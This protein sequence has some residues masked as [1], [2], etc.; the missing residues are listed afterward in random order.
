MYEIVVGR[1]DSDRKALGIQGSVFLGKHY[2]RMG[3]TTSLSNKIY[4]DVAKTHVVL[5]SGKRGCLTEESMIFT[6]KGYKKINEFDIIKDKIY[7]FNKEK[8]NFILEKAKLLKYK[9]N[10]ELYNIKLDD[11]QEIVATAEHPFLVKANKKYS[12]KIASELNTE[13]KIVSLLKLPNKK[14]NERISESLARL[15]GFTL[16]DGTLFVRKGRFKDGRGYWYNG[17]IKRLRIF[18]AENEVLESAK[19]DIEKEFGVTARRYKRKDCNCEVIEARH[20]KIINKLIELGVPTGEKSKIIRVPKKIF[21]SSKKIKSQFLKAAFSC[22][23]FVSKNGANIIYYSNS[24]LFLK[25]LGLLLEDFGI[26]SKIRPKKTKC[27]GKYF[28]S[29]CLSIWDYNSIKNFQNE[30]SFFSKEKRNRVENKKFWR[31]TRRKKT[32]YLSENLFFQKI[33]KINKEKRDT[34]VYDLRVPK[35]HSFIV[36]GIISHNSGKSYTLGV[37][38]E[39]M[40]HLPPEVKN[41]IAVL[42]L[43]TMGIFWTM[44]FPNAK[45]EDLLDEWNLP[46]KSLD[47]NIY[48]PKGKFQ[49]YKDKG[50]PADF[51]FTI[52]PSELSAL[53]W[54]NSFNVKTIDPIGVAIESTLSKL[55]EE[56]E[57]YSVEEIILAIEKNIKLDQNIK[58]ATI[59]R[60]LAAKSWGIFSEESTPIKEIVSAGKVSV[61]DLSAYTE[62]NIKNLVTGIICQKLMEERVIARKKEEM[63]DVK[64]G[65]SY[66]QT[67][68]E[69]TGGELPL[70]WILLDEAHEMLKKDETTPATDALVTILREGRQPGISLILATQQPGEI[71]RDVI[72]QTD[73][74]LSHR[75]TAKR[76]IE[77]LN[78]MM[79]SYLPGAIQKYFNLLP[80]D[81][82]S[83]IILDDNSERIYPLQVRPRFTWHGGEAP[84]ALKSKGKAAKELGL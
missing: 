48:V 50:I 51:P 72:T 19:E 11:G 66:F 15:L 36:N 38:A 20:Q 68:I 23:G 73:I 45:D 76:D 53:D 1:S 64:K 35:N 70:V 13:D 83:A 37:V 57:N 32:E 62:W 12:W 47:I 46:K 9:V 79:Q 55:K 81:R 27:N 28:L 43:D 16:A 77:A 78:S 29:Y 49:S 71:H 8:M 39:E 26:H 2:V 7:S 34:Y 14:V 10:E 18:N 80:K 61:L 5:V 56:K 69:G 67:T 74:V 40:A 82:G 52:N 25:D 59:N 6:D 65:H 54:C 3:N 22:D 60:F 58:L 24:E 30:I 42:M 17:T 41:K 63:E 44:R 75:I 21:L 84:T 4:L 33:L 31:M